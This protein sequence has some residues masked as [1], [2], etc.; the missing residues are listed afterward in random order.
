MKR[1]WIMATVLS[2]LGGTPLHAQPLAQAKVAGIEMPAPWPAGDAVDT[3][4]GVAVPDPYRALENVKDEGVQRW[5]RANA[6]AT[7][8]VL[9]R[10]PERD[11]LLARIQ[12]LDADSGGVTSNLV[13]TQDGRLF[14]LRRN[15]GEQQLRLI[16]RATLDAEMAQDRVLVDPDALSKTAGKPVAIMDFAPSPDGKTLAYSLQ[17]GGG[18]IGALRVIDIAS[19]RLLAGPIDRIRY[20]SVVWNHDSQ[21]FFYTRLREGY[22]SLPATER[23]QD[24]VVHYRTLAGEE[25]AVFSQS[26]Q[27]E[28]KLP[29]IA[30]ARILPLHGRPLALA[31]VT[32]GVERNAMLFIAKLAD[33]QNGTARW[34]KVVDRSDEVSQYALGDGAIYLRSAKGAPRYQV[35]RLKLDDAQAEPKMAQAEL[36]LPQGDGVITSLAGARDGLYFT[37]REG[38]TTSLWK[39]AH[40]KTERIAL[41]LQGT[42]SVRQADQRMDG[43]LLR[44]SSWTRAAVDY[45]WAGGAGPALPLQLAASG[46]YDAPPGMQAREV[47][48]KSHDGVMVP[49]SILSRSDITLDGSN[50]TLLYGYG[51]YG[52][53]ESPGFSARLLAWLERGGVYAIAH[54]RGGGVFGD[55]W[56][57][58]GRKTSKANTWKDGIAVAEWLVHNGYT[59][60][61]KLG[62]FGGSAGGI[63]VGRAA[64]ERPELFAAAVSAVGVLDTVRSETRANGVAN[65][66]EYGSVKQ[67][68][69]F[70][71]LLAMSSYASLKAGTRY[72]AFLL[73]HGVNDIR[74][75]VWQSAKF[76]ARLAALKPTQPVLMRLEYDAGHGQGSSRLQGQERQAD[77]WAFLLWQFGV[78]GF[79]PGS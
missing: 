74:V 31:W 28:L 61:K 16:M 39:W 9:A 50:P 71:A 27:S 3:H 24:R 77:I 19:G 13:R 43:V 22:E 12:A 2:S 53:V 46:A 5:L 29:S 6:D 60:A 25:K 18:E 8:Q 57:Q 62:I 15:P 78:A 40:N 51:A 59:S 45:R 70:R 34:H 48:V 44:V 68:D 21:G 66:P 72:P 58:A 49:V 17:E 36:V 75:D 26:R 30:E 79:Q 35:Y 73:T 1:F 55:A 33:V 32:M 64:T 23:F 4:W 52:S 56:H 76:A 65:V 20:A 47:M 69:E 37:R 38:V 67:E 7:T 54:V 63:F 14:F 41:P 10:L 42:V 11:K